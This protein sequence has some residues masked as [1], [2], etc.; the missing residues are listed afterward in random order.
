MARITVEDCL[1]KVKSRFELVV[2]AAHRAKELLG[3]AKATVSEDDDKVTVLS[4]REIGDSKIQTPD[5][6]DKLVDSLRIHAD[7][8]GEKPFLIDY[9]SI[10]VASRSGEEDAP[11]TSDGDDSEDD[12][13]IGEED[14]T[15][16][17]DDDLE[18]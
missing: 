3:G 12:D 9:T 16:I 5:I 4:L 7:E 6:R 17:P 10:T 13:L 18:E 2:L 8:S 14:F 15:E 1:T 11:S